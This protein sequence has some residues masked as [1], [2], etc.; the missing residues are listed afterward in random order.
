[1]APNPKFIRSGV[2]PYPFEDKQEGLHEQDVDGNGRVL[3]MRLRDPMPASAP[4]AGA[5]AT[6]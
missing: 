6:V 4:T 2:R 5:R 3:Q 1:M